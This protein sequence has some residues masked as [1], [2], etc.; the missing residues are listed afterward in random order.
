MCGVNAPRHDCERERR[1]GVGCARRD[2]KKYG[3]VC[4]GEGGKK[5][6][7]RGRTTR[8]SGRAGKRRHRE[9][10]W[11]KS[12]RQEKQTHMQ[13]MGTHNGKL[14]IWPERAVKQQ[15]HGPHQ[16]F[17]IVPG[18]KRTRKANGNTR[19][20]G[21]LPPVRRGGRNKGTSTDGRSVPPH[22]LSP[23]PP[24]SDSYPPAIRCREDALLRFVT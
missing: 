2:R 22:I 5:V 6:G 24:D 4:K 19:G 18:L 10:S 23:P 9:P 11:G 13:T 12:A 8:L 20:V 16:T 7:K 1:V 21:G 3:D 14:P 17:S 15:S